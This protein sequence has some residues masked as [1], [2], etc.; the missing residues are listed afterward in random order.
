M[1]ATAPSTP[2]LPAEHPVGTEA[3]FRATYRAH[4][5]HVWLTLRRFGVLEAD[6]EDAAHEVFVTA[7]RRRADF[8]PARPIKPWLSG[9]AWRVASH[10]RRARAARR[11]HALDPDGQPEHA[12]PGPSPEQVV[13]LRQTHARLQQALDSIELDQRVILVMHEIDGLPIPEIATSLGVPLNTCYSRLRL[14]RRRF[15]AAV[16]RMHARDAG[17]GPGGRR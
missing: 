1:A 2:A 3:S 13:A 17:P 7:W 14:A 10:A 4:F 15:E 16:T 6:V 8:D 5:R 11:E 9:I 12:H